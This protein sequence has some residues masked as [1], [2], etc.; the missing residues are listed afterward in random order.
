MVDERRGESDARG[1]TGQTGRKVG[2][3]GPLHTEAGDSLRAAHSLD[4]GDKL[5]AAESGVSGR[6]TGHGSEKHEGELLGMANAFNR[7][8]DGVGWITEGHEIG[9]VVPQLMVVRVGSVAIDEGGDGA[10]GFGLPRVFIVAPSNISRGKG[11][12]EEGNLQVRVLSP[13]D[14]IINVD[15]LD[16]V[17]GREGVGA[18]G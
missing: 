13:V 1:V 9:V 15:H 8:G 14:I 6:P 4:S 5:E 3:A 17:V 12:Q 16:D 10:I 18:L 7:V 2:F 11:I